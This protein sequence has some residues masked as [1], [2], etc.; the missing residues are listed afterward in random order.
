LRGRL[1]WGQRALFAGLFFALAVGVGFLAAFVIGQATA[2]ALAI[3]APL[4]IVAGAGLVRIKPRSVVSM[5]ELRR[6]TYPPHEPTVRMIAVDQL[7]ER[8]EDGESEADVF[9]SALDDNDPHVRVI[10]L[11]AV[12]RHRI[13]SLRP[14]VIRA[15]RDPAW[16][17]RSGAGRAL[18][19]IGDAAAL[20]SMEA[21]AKRETALPRLLQRVRCRRLRARLAR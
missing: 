18:V 12:G 2:S 15:L 8:I 11:D 7:G 20:E 3:G 19:V 14:A 10:A 6:M 9:A 1:S 21:A 16:I 13:S 17:V 4:V 5:S